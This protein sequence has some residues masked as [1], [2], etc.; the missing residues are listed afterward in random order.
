[1]RGRFDMILMSGLSGAGMFSAGF[2]ALTAAP[3]HDES[4]I[5]IAA[6]ALDR[7][8]STRPLPG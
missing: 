8:S 1:V 4:V 2:I 6:T 7:F 3:A 5:G